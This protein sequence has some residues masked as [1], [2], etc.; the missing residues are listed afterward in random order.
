MPILPHQV[1]LETKLHF[2]L[3]IVSPPLLGSLS[4]GSGVERVG[5]EASSSVYVHVLL[6]LPS[7]PQFTPFIQP[8]LV[9]F[10]HIM[11]WPEHY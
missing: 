11:V 1:S 2:C 10:R 9:G 4:R 8:L 3:S 5:T 7:I 6:V